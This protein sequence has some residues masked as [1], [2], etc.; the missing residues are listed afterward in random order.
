MYDEG[1]SILLAARVKGSVMPVTKNSKRNATLKLCH[2]RSKKKRM[3]RIDY[4]T[5]S[6][7]MS[8]AQPYITATVILRLCS[9][10]TSDRMLSQRLIFTRWPCFPVMQR[11]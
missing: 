6:P 3:T 11:L 5:P 2:G 4:N 9:G 1:E 8:P 7:G 10:G